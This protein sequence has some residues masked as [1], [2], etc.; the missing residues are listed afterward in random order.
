MSDETD[1]LRPGGR[2]YNGDDG[3]GREGY[4]GV[5]WGAVQSDA[6]PREFGRQ[7]G[8]YRTGSLRM[9]VEVVVPLVLV[10]PATPTPA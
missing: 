4:G 2:G 9:R 3:P 10:A 5:R 6:G 1:T 8:G 7:A